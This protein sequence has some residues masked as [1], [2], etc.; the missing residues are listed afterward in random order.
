M[1]DSNDPARRVQAILDALARSLLEATDEEIAGDLKAIEAE[2]VKVDEQMKFS[3]DGAIDSFYRAKWE[4]LR[5]E[6]QHRINGYAK[7]VEAVPTSPEQCRALLTEVLA[8]NAALK[9]SITAQF[10]ELE[11]L[12]RL[13]DADVTGVVR[14]LV[15]PEF[16]KVKHAGS[17]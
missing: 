6:R 3:I 2:P 8:S 14:N 17:E 1:A 11:D 10:R 9:S 15:A 4:A 7:C 5:Q 12:G 16:I 13:S